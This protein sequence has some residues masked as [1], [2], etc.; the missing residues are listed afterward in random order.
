MDDDIVLGYLVG[1][2]VVQENPLSGHLGM[3]QG[4]AK[5]PRMEELP[6]R[7]ESSMKVLTH[8]TSGN[9]LRHH[10]STDLPLRIGM[11]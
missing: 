7:A 8:V 11:V 1:G 5:P 4:W 3:F 2:T 6:I 9:V 10:Y